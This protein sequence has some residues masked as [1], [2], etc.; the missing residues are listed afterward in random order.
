MTLLL[1]PKPNTCEFFFGSLSCF[2]LFVNLILE[3]FLFNL[4]WEKYLLPSVLWAFRCEHSG[5]CPL[6]LVVNLLASM[7]AYLLVLQMLVMFYIHPYLD[8]VR[9]F[10]CGAKLSLGRVSSRSGNLAQDK[11]AYVKFWALPSYYSIRPSSTDTSSFCWKLCLL[12][13]PDNLG[14]FAGDRHYFLRWIPLAWCWLL[15]P[16]PGPL[17]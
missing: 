1:S 17:L 4:S 2:G 10:P 14:W 3:Q 13:R 12:L 7:T 15:L 8:S 9:S 11:V 16:R 5:N 6:F